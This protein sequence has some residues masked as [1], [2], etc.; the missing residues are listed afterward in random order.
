MKFITASIEYN[1]FEKNIPAPYI[2]KSFESEK[3]TKAKLKIAVCGFYELYFNGENITK[4]FLAPYISNTDHYV[5]CDEYEVTVKKGENVI[6]VLLGNG[7][8]NNPGGW[9]WEFDKARFRSA[10][11]FALCLEFEDK[12]I[13]SG[14]DFKVHA[15]P[16]VY[17]DYRYG[18]K[19][20]ANHE[21]DGWNKQGFDDLSWANALCAL[22]PKGE[23]STC[24]AEPITADF[25][26]EPI[27]IFA[28][29]DGFVYDFGVCHSGVCKL[30]ID[31]KKGQEIVL[32]H[33]EI[34]KNGKFN[35]DNLCCDKNRTEQDL[36]FIHKDVYVCKD[37]KQTYIPKF[38]YHGFRYVKVTGVTK[39]QA[40]K[41]L[42]KFV[43][44]HSNLETRGGFSCSDETLNKLQEMTRRSDISNFHYFPTDCPQREKNGWTADVALS[45]EHI[46]L[47]FGAE[48]S[49]CEWM[50]NVCKAQNENGAIPCVVPAGDWGY[51]WGSGPAWDCALVFVPYYTYMY[52]GNSKIIEQS[53]DTIYKYLNYLLTKK[54]ENSLVHFGLG[55]WCHAGRPEDC[56]KAPLEVT[57]TIIS[58]AIAERS[59]FLFGIIGDT[60][61]RD[62]ALKIANNFKKAIREN[63]IDFEQMTVKGN[64]QTSQALAI[65]YGVFMPEETGDAFEKLLHFIH[66]ADD[67]I[68]CGVLG[69]R[70]IFHLLSQFG[71][72]DLAYKMI[73]RKD[74]PSYRYWIEQ[75]AT[76][77]WENFDKEKIKSCNH[78]FWGDISGWFIKCIAGIN[79]N[80]N[81]DNIKY[82]E[83]KPNFVKA[84][85]NAD[86]YYITP[87]GKV[88]S[89]WKRVKDKIILNLEIP[90]SITAKIILPNGYS[91]EKDCEK[92]V[93]T[94]EYIIIKDGEL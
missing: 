1:T 7:F 54:D 58:M 46:L 41:D 65:Y 30:T 82:L 24:V 75:G 73:T 13:E 93:I 6:G 53:A 84:L 5:Y 67:H 34:L 11:K 71:F 59:A 36:K 90:K 88:V 17:D 37:G 87:F 44:M 92:S 33:G 3:E 86:G 38:T 85:N 2:R 8:Q 31:A 47:N 79:Y 20:D 25:E 74:F 42:L 91:M 89:R 48:K 23:I 78:H 76:T 15:S 62:F 70:V 55:D 51:G 12:K 26:I 56:P 40:T 4:G 77:L 16:I 18:T 63:L 29:D 66:L 19:Y 69:G 32:T 14:T 50:K 72:V 57:D 28:E 60:K 61:R 80:P 10:P 45:C 22:T 64:C 81:A 83:I 9:V 43:V 49:F 68:D 21:I 27:S 39:S 52:S 35:I 94:G